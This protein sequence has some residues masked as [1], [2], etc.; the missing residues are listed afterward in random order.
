MSA[1]KVDRFEAEEE[2]KNEEV[3][4]VRINYIKLRNRMKKLGQLLKEKEK[5][6]DGVWACDCGFSG[7]FP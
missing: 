2:Q 5:L 7:A 3:R 4:N 1:D 6:T